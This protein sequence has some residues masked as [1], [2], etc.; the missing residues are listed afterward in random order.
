M[1][2][3]MCI[4]MDLWGYLHLYVYLYVCVYKSV[5]THDFTTSQMDSPPNAETENSFQAWKWIK[6]NRKLIW[7]IRGWMFWWCCLGIPPMLII[8]RPNSFS[9]LLLQLC[10]RHQGAKLLSIH[11][12]RCGLEKI[13]RPFLIHRKCR[14]RNPCEITF[15]LTTATRKPCRYVCFTTIKCFSVSS[16]LMH[17]TSVCSS[18]LHQIGHLSTALNRDP[19]KNKKKQTWNPR[20]PKKS[21][22]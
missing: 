3:P 19:E 9:L 2:V 7:C 6:K 12:F 11:N 4:D 8:L 17:S 15:E 16:T 13:P 5:N 21:P 18:M 14:C 20:Q 1:S 22:P 10:L